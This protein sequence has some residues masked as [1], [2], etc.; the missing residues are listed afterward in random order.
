MRKLATALVLIGC[1]LALAP[2]A[3]AQDYRARVQGSVVDTSQA[4]PA[5]RHRRR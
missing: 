1:L 4:R 5:W 3:M 2:A